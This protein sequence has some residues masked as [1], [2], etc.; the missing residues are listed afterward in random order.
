MK[1]CLHP[2]L[3]MIDKYG[4]D[5]LRF[6]LAALAVP[7]M[8]LALSEERMAGYQ[9]FVNK[10]CNASRFVLMNLK[11]EKPA[12]AEA[13]LTLADRW[14]RSRLAAVTTALETSLRQYKFYEAA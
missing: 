11:T 8:D 9:A 10:I 4:T 1:N 7:G 3:E 13:E 6:T 14:I 2:P 5:A 12:V